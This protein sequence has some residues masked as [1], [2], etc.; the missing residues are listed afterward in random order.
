MS[1]GVLTAESIIIAG[2]EQL[3]SWT[4]I[5]RNGWEAFV[6]RHQDGLTEQERQQLWEDFSAMKK[7][8]ASLIPGEPVRVEDSAIVYDPS[9]MEENK[10]YTV[11]VLGRLHLVRKTPKNVVETFEVE[12][13][14]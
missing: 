14:K 9:R 12:P 1:T 7:L 2:P 3:L 5:C 10:I 13:I 6:R 11:E 8:I 4:T